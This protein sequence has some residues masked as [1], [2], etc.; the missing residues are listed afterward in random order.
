MTRVDEELTPATIRS[1]LERIPSALRGGAQYVDER[2]SERAGVPVIVKVETVNPVRSYKGRGT[3]LAIREL[4]ARGRLGPDRP[5]VVASTGNF[6]QGAGYAGRALGIPVRVFADEHANP[7]KLERI[8]RLGATVVQS[9]RDFDEAREA[10]AADARRSGS[11]LLIDGEEP[12]VATG[13]AT[14][15]LE[16]TDAVARGELPAPAAAYVPVGNGAL[17]VGIGAWLRHAAPGCRVIGIQSDA[18]PSMTLS[19]RAGHPVET[20]TASTIAEGIATR[21]PVPEALDM[22]VER[23]DEMRLVRES[24]LPAATEEL[25]AAVGVTAEAAAGASWAGVLADPAPPGPVLVIVTGANV[26]PAGATR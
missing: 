11:L 7:V 17:I 6:G 21:V 12:W 9:G 18:A 8:R 13:A 4:A 22:M 15:A 14:I 25:A 19:W 26:V 20:E 2:L 24:D 16:V 1:A 5:V 10:A 23:V 3:W